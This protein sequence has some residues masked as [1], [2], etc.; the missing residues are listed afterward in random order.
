[1]SGSQAL[2]Q[3]HKR[4]EYQGRSLPTH[5]LEKAPAESLS[6]RLKSV[7]NK[8]VT[9][10]DQRESSSRKAYSSKI[11]SAMEGMSVYHGLGLLMDSMGANT[12][13]AK[14]VSVLL[15]GIQA[16]GLLAPFYANKQSRDEAELD[17]N[18]R[19]ASAMQNLRNPDRMVLPHG[20]RPGTVARQF[21]NSYN[22]FRGVVQAV[23]Q[24]GVDVTE[25]L[26]SGGLNSLSRLGSSVA[27]QVA[28]QRAT[29]SRRRVPVDIEM[30]EGAS[31]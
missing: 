9:S 18:T 1:M 6:S 7:W 2:G 28:Q 22:R 5:V 15:T 20:T 21:E 23:P 17:N 25:A 12:A 26:V 14:V 24:A 30:G 3:Q 19:F 27:E 10:V 16:I 29:R 8:G 31:G 11:Y 4:F 13:P